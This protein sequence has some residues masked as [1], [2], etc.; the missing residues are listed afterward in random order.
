MVFTG[1]KYPEINNEV[2]QSIGN[3]VNFSESDYCYVDSQ[4]TLRIDIPKELCCLIGD[5]PIFYRK[6]PVLGYCCRW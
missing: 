3:D 5:P 1:N 4:C 2:D 6:T